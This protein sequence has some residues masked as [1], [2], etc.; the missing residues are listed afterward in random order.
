[1]AN[2]QFINQ[3]KKGGQVLIYEDPDYEQKSCYINILPI[4]I[5]QRLLPASSQ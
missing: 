1:M 4:G 5:K 2:S 3:E